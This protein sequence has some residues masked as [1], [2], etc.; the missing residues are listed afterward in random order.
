M[1]YKSDLYFNDVHKAF[2]LDIKGV[3]FNIPDKPP[4]VDFKYLHKKQAVRFVVNLSGTHL[5]TSKGIRSLILL[6]ESAESESLQFHI[7]CENSALY[8]TMTDLSLHRMFSI[9]MDLKN[10]PAV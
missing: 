4:V 1:N 2:I 8:N 10:L 3:F 5:L 9:V 7:L 6:K